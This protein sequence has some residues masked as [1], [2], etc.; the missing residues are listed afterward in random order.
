MNLLVF[1]AG[2]MGMAAAYNLASSAAVKTVTLADSDPARARAAAARVNRLTRSRKARATR[3][4]AAQAE[5]LVP[6]LARHAGALSAAPYFYNLDLAKAAI[7]AG[8]HFADLGGNNT[9]VRRELALD[10]RARSAGVALAPDCGLSPGL[11]SIFAAELLRRAGGRAQALKIYVGGLPQRPVPP[12][13]Y[14]LV[15]SVEG[16]IN[17]YAEPARILRRGQ[18]QWIA[19]LSE[20]EIFRL[21]GLPALEAFHTSGG[22][23]TLPESFAGQVGECFE[24][25]LRYPG[26][27]ALV[28]GLY[29]LG[30]FSSQPLAAGGARV[31]PRALTASLMEKHFAGEAPEMTILRVEAHRGRRILSFTLIDRTDPRTGLTSMMRTTAWPAAIILRLL[32]EG[33]IAAR[34]ALLQER[35][36]PFALFAR[37]LR[38]CGLRFRYRCVEM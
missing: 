24:K 25:T 9:V 5:S 19:P 21:R 16:L 18:P 7:R 23:S 12:F 34:G 13:N 22:A 30:L 20:P 29:D 31:V 11:A 37:Q 1:G 4:D 38:A 17:E 26:H 32:A 28:R 33:T 36:I 27:L 35:D 14:Q 10:G 2:R 3:A 8:C 6:L 15:F